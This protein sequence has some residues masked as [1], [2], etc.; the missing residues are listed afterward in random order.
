[1]HSNKKHLNIITYNL[2]LLPNLH[3]IQKTHP[4]TSFIHFQLVPQVQPQLSPHSWRSNSQLLPQQRSTVQPLRFARPSNDVPIGHPEDSQ[5]DMFVEISE[6][7]SYLSWNNEDLYVYN[8]YSSNVDILWNVTSLGY[9]PPE[10]A[11]T[12]CEQQEYFDPIVLLAYGKLSYCLV[13]GSLVLVKF[14]LFSS[15]SVWS[16]GVS[17]CNCY[18]YSATP[19][20][21]TP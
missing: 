1:M 18:I 4:S 12:S 5:R 2:Y 17:G 9:L 3:S 20:P 14:W 7:L 10:T 8:M 15:L 11:P 13:M 6:F 19:D 16:T 21:Q